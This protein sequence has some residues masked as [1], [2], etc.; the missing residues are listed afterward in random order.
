MCISVIPTYLLVPAGA[1][2]GIEGKG[3]QG[4]GK[5]GE[6]KGKGNEGKL[7]FAKIRIHRMGVLPRAARVCVCACMA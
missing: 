7:V 6:G 1:Y 5:A 4:K 2:E 3:R